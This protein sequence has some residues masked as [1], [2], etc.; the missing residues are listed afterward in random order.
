[1]KERSEHSQAER[2]PVCQAGGKK[3]PRC[4]AYER[5]P[6]W[7]WLQAV[8]TWVMGVPHVGQQPYF[9][10]HSP[11]RAV[12]AVFTMLALS[13]LSSALLIVLIP[14]AGLLM[15][16]LLALALPASL[17][18]TS[19]LLRAL[20][21][22]VLHYAS[23]G[24]FGRF[25]ELIGEAAAM[26]GFAVPLATYR[27]A[28]NIHHPS[29][30][31]EKDPDQSFIEEIIAALGQSVEAYEREL[32]RT[33]LPGAKFLREQ[34]G[35]WQNNFGSDQ[36]LRRK[37]T[38]AIVLT[39][40]VAIAVAVSLVIG[41]PMPLIV[42]LLAWALPLTYGVW[43][44]KVL[45]AIGLH[46][47]FC[48]PDPQLSARENY[49]M[50]TGARFF[51]DEVPARELPLLRRYAAW[52]CY[53]LRFAFVHLLVGKAF[54][55]GFS[56]NQQHDAHHVNGREFKFWIAPYSR[57]EMATS[58]RYEMWHTFGSVMTAIRENFKYWSKLSK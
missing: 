51:G 57:H 1:M 13:V 36:P 37:L 32:L 28:H 30:A 54:V 24:A 5:L 46:V 10:H 48:Q 9:S 22:Y 12:V 14:Q 52:A 47:Y 15:K 7:A 3:C 2:C 53:L 42:W 58:G 23:H 38:L 50:K 55:M 29:V 43:V 40:P 16:P 25:N 44:S 17:M 31:T 34:Q 49:Q 21:I 20:S 27:R 19:G 6:K 39:L 41:S 56:D 45:F 35:R 11:H 8:I 26:I 18:L 4:Q 33:L